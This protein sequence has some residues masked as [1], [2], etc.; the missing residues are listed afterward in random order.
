MTTH[1]KILTLKNMASN[2]L[3]SEWEIHDGRSF[4]ICKAAIL[5]L[6]LFFAKSTSKEIDV[7]IVCFYPLQMYNNVVNQL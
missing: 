4:L 1:S 3:Y 7:Q 6:F 2:V 5:F